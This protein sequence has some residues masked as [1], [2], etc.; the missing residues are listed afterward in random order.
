[1]IRILAITSTKTYKSR[2]FLISD[3]MRMFFDNLKNVQKIYGS[4]EDYVFST[5][6][7]N[8]HCKT[9]SDCIRI[10]AFR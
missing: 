6:E 5:S 4:Y 3:E 8:V 1:M 9:I 2:R 10:N 7:G